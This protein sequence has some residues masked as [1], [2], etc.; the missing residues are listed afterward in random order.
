M[1]QVEIDEFQ[2]YD[3]A[4]EAFMEAGACLSKITAPKDPKQHERITEV[5]KQR[6]A[7][8][9]RFV[10]IKKLFERGDIQTGNFIFTLNYVILST[11]LTNW[12]NS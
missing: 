11:F 1:F 9:K 12:P 6:S 10:D 2:N 8:I 5:I 7:I 4:Y 3:K